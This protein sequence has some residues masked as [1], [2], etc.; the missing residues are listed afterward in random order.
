MEKLFMFTSAPQPAKRPTAHRDARHAQRQ[1]ESRVSVEL[2]VYLP[3]IP[4]FYPSFGTRYRSAWRDSAKRAALSE[5]ESF[6]CGIWTAAGRE[7]RPAVPARNRLRSTPP[8]R[9]TGDSEVDHEGVFLK[10]LL[11]MHH[12]LRREGYRSLRRGDP[13]RAL[14]VQQRQV[15]PIGAVVVRN[16]PHAVAEHDVVPQRHARRVHLEHH[17]QL[18]LLHRHFRP[19]LHQ[20]HRLC[21]P[22]PS[23]PQPASSLLA[24]RVEHRLADRVAHLVGVGLLAPAVALSSPP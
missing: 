8:Q 22:A 24:S 20:H 10:G 15:A 23:L 6:P 16:A 17:A 11:Q 19:V 9:P 18:A 4:R 12:Q 13:T 5:G 21:A 2:H 1:I 14:A 7:S 3:P